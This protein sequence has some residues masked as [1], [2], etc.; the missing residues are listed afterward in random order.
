MKKKNYPLVDLTINRLSPK[1]NGIATYQHPAGIE[2]TV[3]VPFTIPGDVVKAKIYKKSKGLHLSSLEEIITPSP[4]RQAP[5]CVHF[6][7]CGG[8]RWQQMSYS[9]QLQ[10]KQKSVQ[11][12]FK[13]MLNDQIIFSPIVPSDHEW[14]YRNKME[15]SFSQNAQGEH[16]LG[17]MVDA[18][19]GKVLNLTECHLVHPWFVT[20]L[21]AVRKWWADSDLKAFHP[22]RNTGSL[23]V[24]TVREGMHTGDKLVMLTVSG[25]PDYA[26]TKEQITSFTETVKEAIEPTFPRDQLSI[27]L[28]IHQAVKGTPTSFYEMHLY[29]PDHLNETMQVTN[30]SRQPGERLTFNISPSAFFQPNTDQAEKFYSLALQMADASKSSVVYD[31]YCGTGTIGLSLASHVKHV[32]GIEASPEAALDAKTNAALNNIKNYQVFCGDVR[33][34]LKTVFTEKELPPPDILIIDPPRVGLEAEALEYV[35][36]FNVPTIVYISCN[37]KTQAANVS[38][39]LEAG[40]HITAIQPV[41]QFPHTVH[42]ENIVIL[43]K[44]HK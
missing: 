18:G 30:A 3:E 41:D 7:I 32:V 38:E 15:F 44:H 37:P 16:Y 17:L 34:V 28:R 40:Y 11:H 4:H 42:I 23:R 26:L 27:F 24:L 13:A 39:M 10:W 14:Q 6:G 29:G 20:V 9:D 5:R 33:H 35:L 12:A 19:R 21:E 25:N 31:L 2:W 1:G 36:A 43:K 8:C 22:Y